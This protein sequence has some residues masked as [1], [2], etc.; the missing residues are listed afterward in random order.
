MY[1]PEN[2]VALYAF[3]QTSETYLLDD[4]KAF[5]RKYG[6]EWEFQQEKGDTGYIHWQGWISL[7]KKRRKSEIIK[8]VKDSGDRLFEY[9]VPAVG[10]DES[11]KSYCAKHD[12]RIAGPFS[13]KDQEFFM[14]YQ[15]DGI[16]ETLYPFQ[17]TIWN[18]CATRN[19]RQINFVFDAT[20]CRGKSAVASLIELYDKGIDVP[21]VNDMKELLQVVC[22]ECYERTR[23]PKCF[24]FDMP[25]AL[26]KSRLYGMYSAIEQIKKGK[27]YDMR[28]HYKK[29]WIHA[30]QI[31]VFSNQPPDLGMLSADRWNL[32][33]IDDKQCL[34]EY[35][36]EEP[37]AFI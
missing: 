21:P 35:E 24:L 13:Y 2:A 4:V 12:T 3:R 28:Y 26:D 9:F 25:R 1:M 31:W 33:M 7:L 15:Y 30:P 16:L 34:V 20:G 27:L 10:S 36:E 32:W 11:I 29:W 14:P 5:C 37:N 6:K 8:V 17:Q 19:P 23:D 22:D 18:S